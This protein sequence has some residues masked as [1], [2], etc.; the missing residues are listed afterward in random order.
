MLKRW[1]ILLLLL[2]ILPISN[3]YASGGITLSSSSVDIEKGKTQVI[4]VNA[5]NLAGRIDIRT[6]D[7]TIVSI[8]KTSYF[9]DTSLDNNKVN[10]TLTAKKAG[11][12]KIIVTLTD[13]ATFDREVLT[14]TR[15]IN[16]NVKK[17]TPVITCKEV[18]LTFNGVEQTFGNAT[19]NSDGVI[20]YSNNKGTQV[21]T[22]NYTVNVSET[23]EYSSGIKTC[24]AKI[25]N[26]KEEVVKLQPTITC[27]DVEVVYTGSEQSFGNV[28]T[29]SDG[30]ISYSGNNGTEVGTYYYI[31]RVS[32]TDNYKAGGKTCIARIVKREEKVKAD[33]VIKCNDVEIIYTGKEQVFGNATTDSDGKISYSENKGTDVGTYQYTVHVLETDLYNEG[34]KTCEAKIITVSDSVNA[35][36][37]I[38]SSGSV[39]TI[40][41]IIIAILSAMLVVSILIIFK[42]KKM[43]V[44]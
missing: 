41:V 7:D 3:V 42:L 17:K 2:L 4:S 34:F 21:G 1:K 29:D 22:Y 24:V 25:I 36:D 32:E 8:N 5:S 27:D 40:L 20:S 12:A 19:T 44:K 13:I 26:K 23:S 11:S 14:G 30:I 10:I 18:S 37:N 9:F 43:I 39:N 33:P 31:V 28:T 35:S 15:E 6:T 38:N 16:V